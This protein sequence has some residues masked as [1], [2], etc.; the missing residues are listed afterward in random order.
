MNNNI[1]QASDVQNTRALHFL[2]IILAALLPLVFT[3]KSFTQTSLLRIIFSAVFI[4]VFYID[5]AIRIVPNEHIYSQRAG[6]FNIDLGKANRDISYF[7]DAAFYFIRGQLEENKGWTAKAIRT[8]RKAVKLQP[9]GFS[10]VKAKKRLE[11][12]ENH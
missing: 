11:I 9:A 1:N 3:F 5:K 12:L 7:N 10:G 4:S 2:L 6:R 8:Y